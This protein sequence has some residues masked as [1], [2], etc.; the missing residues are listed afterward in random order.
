MHEFQSDPF[1]YGKVTLTSEVHIC[2]SGLRNGHES[3]YNTKRP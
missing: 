2:V 3:K 1:R